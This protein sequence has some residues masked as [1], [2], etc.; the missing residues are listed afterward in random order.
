M[1]RRSILAAAGTG[2]AAGALAPAVHA[3]ANVRWRLASSFPKSLDIPF[4]AAATI[5][6]RVSAL[7]GGRFQISVH[8]G[9]ELV[10][11]L[12]VFDAVQGG[13]VECAHTCSYYFIGKQRALAFDTGLPF[14]LTARQQNAWHLH[15]GGLDLVRELYRPYGIVPFPAGNTGA[16]MGGWYRKEVKTVA[17]LR[18]LKMRIPGLAGEIMAKLG[19]V[20]QQIPGGEV[21]TALEK[22][23]IDAAEWVGPHDDEKLG[24]YRVAPFYYY[25]GWWEGATTLTL[26][27][28]AAAWERLPDDFKSALEV[29]CLEANAD[30][31]ARYDAS[32]PLAL[33]K[34]VGS[35]A[36]LRAFSS[37]ILDAARVAAGEVYQAEADTNPAF[38]KIYES[39]LPFRE[40][41]FA[42]A[43]ISE[44]MYANYLYSRP[45]FRREQ[46]A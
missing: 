18:G 34:L 23:T 14:G 22:G 46:K 29:A 28:N 27:V 11:P 8:A 32:N 10:P 33:R 36:R 26:Q 4:G 15:A 42:W 3:Q 5:S 21:Y 2:V 45:G 39:W 7:T 41:Q 19:V 1:K 25:P 31:L 20:P 30:A 44:G 37:E 24:F 12:G 38:R 16:Q 35:G 43:R 40:N 13:T 17:D 6:R 9:G